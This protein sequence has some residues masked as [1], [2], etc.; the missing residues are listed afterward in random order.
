MPC[1]GTAETSER[2]AAAGERGRRRRAGRGRAAPPAGRPR[3][4]FQPARGHGLGPGGHP[5]PALPTA[6]LVPTWRPR[7]HVVTKPPVKSCLLKPL[8][9]PPSTPNTAQRGPSSAIQTAHTSL[10]LRVRK[11]CS[12]ESTLALRCVSG[13]NSRYQ[14]KPTTFLMGA[15]RCCFSPD[16]HPPWDSCSDSLCQHSAPTF[17]FIDGFSRCCPSSCCAVTLTLLASFRPDGCTASLHQMGQPSGCEATQSLGFLFSPSNLVIFRKQCS[18]KSRSNDP[19]SLLIA[20]ISSCC[21]SCQ[22]SFWLD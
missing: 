1:A 13:F 12:C 21:N 14:R 11:A 15:G 8:S 19:R 10:T 9:M 3:C 20:V 22:R 18:E 16:S 7:S 5:A 2:P 4:H 17:P 6:S